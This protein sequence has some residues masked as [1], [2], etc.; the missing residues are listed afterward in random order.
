MAQNQECV[1]DFW[2]CPFLL[3]LLLAC[4]WSY[5]LRFGSAYLVYVMWFR[6][7]ILCF[8]DTLKKSFFRKSYGIVCKLQKLSARKYALTAGASL[9]F[10]LFIL[11]LFGDHTW[12]CPGM[13][14]GSL[15]QWM[16]RGCN[17]GDGTWACSISGKHP[18]YLLT[19]IPA[20][21]HWSLKT[22]SL[23]LPQTSQ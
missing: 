5:L 6:V 14:P 12:Y 21:H 20:C 13:T 9:R 18:P 11:L 8:Y 3:E 1:S 15:L 22:R 10:C 7:Y 19:L 23:S 17:V 2:L 4:C 16:L